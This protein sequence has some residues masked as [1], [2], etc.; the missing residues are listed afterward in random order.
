MSSGS[1]VSVTQKFL[2]LT[3]LSRYNSTTCFRITPITASVT[4][5]S[6]SKT[7]AS[8]ADIPSCF[9]LQC[10]TVTPFFTTTRNSNRKPAKHQFPLLHNVELQHCKEKVGTTREKVGTTRDHR[11]KTREKQVNLPDFN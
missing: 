6:G 11:T 4:A 2:G 1:Y 10:T 8:S 9:D 7:Y 3:L 5:T